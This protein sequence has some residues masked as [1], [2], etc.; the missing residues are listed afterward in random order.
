MTTPP[1]PDAFPDA[2]ATILV[3][4]D[5]PETSRAWVDALAAAGH[6]ASL[7]SLD[8]ADPQM[9]LSLAPDLCAVDS[10]AEHAAVLDC[11]RVLREATAIPLALFTTLADEA[12][13]L[14]AYA[15]GLDMVVAHPVSPR[16]FVTMVDAWLGRARA[17]PAA[18]ATGLH[19]G[20]FTLYQIRRRLETPDGGAIKLT[21]LEARLL[22]VLMR[23]PGRPMEADRLVRWV[24][25]HDYTP[26]DGAMLKN[27]VYRLRRKIEPDPCAPRCLVTSGGDGYSFQGDPTAG[28]IKTRSQNALNL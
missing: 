12:H 10:R 27:L 20:G 28:K 18:F 2:P 1:A 6:H 15:A 9:M 16:L 17:L 4:S 13:L 23:Q 14:A 22:Y 8:E 21:A 24:W 11:C 5:D 7:V 25:G 26:G 19:V 3:I